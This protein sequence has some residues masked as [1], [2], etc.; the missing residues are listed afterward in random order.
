MTTFVRPARAEDQD[1]FIKWAKHKPALDSGILKPEFNS[2][3]L[4]AFNNKGI[5]AFLPIQS[6][7]FVSVQMLETLI[8]NP[9]ASDLE[10]ASAMRELVKHAITIGYLKECGELYFIGDHSETNKIAE[11][12]FEKI[13]YPVYRLRLADLEG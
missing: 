2:Y 12:I 11:R 8:S 1:L 5:T 9:E 4:C 3:I 10:I 13:E 6:P 7:Q